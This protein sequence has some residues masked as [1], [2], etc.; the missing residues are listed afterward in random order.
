MTTTETVE[1][2]DEDRA[3]VLAYWNEN[4]SPQSNIYVQSVNDDH[5][6]VQVI[7]AHRIAAEKRQRERDA[8]IATSFLVGDPNN[9]IPLR[10]P[11]AHEIADAIRTQEQDQ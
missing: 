4:L 10:N 2:T 6:L 9:G 8:Q 5:P 7:A 3:R 11:M 1:V